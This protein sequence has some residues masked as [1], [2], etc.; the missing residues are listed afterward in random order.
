MRSNYLFGEPRNGR[1]VAITILTVLIAALCCCNEP[2]DKGTTQQ[3]ALSSSEKIDSGKWKSANECAEAAAKFWNR[4]EWKDQNES[5]K[6]VTYTNHYNAKLNKCLVDVHGVEAV[7][8]GE[9]YESDH[10]YDALE[11]KVL[12]ARW[13]TKK[14]VDPDAEAQQTVFIKDGRPVRQPEDVAA[15]VPWFNGLMVD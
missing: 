15:F 9:V 13:L 3:Q 8:K 12:G 1:A 11:N 4:N 14:A 10:I 5:G 6:S 7:T 2:K